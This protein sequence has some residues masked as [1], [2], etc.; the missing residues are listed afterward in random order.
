MA[1]VMTTPRTYARPSRGRPC[2][3]R[4][5]VP[6]ARPALA[7]VPAPVAHPRRRVHSRAMYWRRRVVM[8][9]LALGTVVVAGQAGAALGGSPLAP[10]ERRSPLVTY[11]VQPGDTMWDVAGRVAPSSDRRPTV[12]A[13]LAARHHTP[14]I[15][16][17][18]ITWQ[19]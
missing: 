17:E 11:V 19:P 18:T 3:G 15:P 10:S 8:A 12:D 1:A 4:R 13:L 14:L 16:G 6:P 9:A 5:V 7:L 2:D